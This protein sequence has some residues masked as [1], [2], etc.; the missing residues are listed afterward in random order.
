MNDWVLLIDFGASFSRAAIVDDAGRVEPVEVDGAATVPSGVWADSKGR[1]VTGVAARQQ[2]RLAPERW[3][4]A[5]KRALGQDTL[6]LGST[7]VP[8]TDAVAAVLRRLSTEAIKRRGRAPREVRLL[9]PARWDAPRRQALLAAARS[10]G[11]DRPKISGGA[12]LVDT[13]FAAG[14]FL[15]ATGRLPAGAK[16]ALFD[17]GGGGVETSVIEA[18]PAPIGVQARAAAAAGGSGTPGSAALVVVDRVVVRALGGLVGLGGEC[19]DDLLHKQVAAALSGID[20]ARLLE[21]PDAEWRRA[22]EG[23]FREVRRAKEELS[24]V[25][26]VRLDAGPLIN[27]PLQLT[28]INLEALLRPEIL[29][30]ARELAATIE[31]AGLRPRALH[32]VYLT[33]GASRMPLVARAVYDVLGV[34]PQLLDES[35]FLAGAAGWTPQDQLDPGTTRITS[36]GRSL[37]VLKPFLP[38]VTGSIPV[39]RPAPPEADEAPAGA[40]AGPGGAATGNGKT[41]KGNTRPSG[42]G[43]SSFGAT[44]A[45]A[46]GAG[47]GSGRSAF[48]TGSAAGAFGAG[49]AAGNSSAGQGSGGAGAASGG[50]AASGKSAGTKARAAEARASTTAGDRS[51][52]G[53]TTSGTTAGKTTFGKRTGAE[54][55]GAEPWVSPAVAGSRARTGSSGRGAGVGGGGGPSA[56]ATRASSEGEETSEAATGRPLWRRP[57]AVAVAVAVV[58]LLIGGLALNRPSSGSED[59]G[60]GTS[61]ADLPTA[62]P[63]A[64]PSPTSSLDVSNS[65]LPVTGLT[66]TTKKI[67]VELSWQS[68][69]GA[70]SYLVLRDPGEPGQASKPVAGT[71]FGDRPGDGAPHTYSVVAVDHTGEAGP[72]GASVAA[73]PAQT[74]YGAE[75]DI[76]SDWVGL[77]PAVPG[78]R[79]KLGQVCKGTK[80]SSAHSDGRIACRLKHG[81]QFQ[82]LRFPSKAERDARAAQLDHAK[83]VDRS[84]WSVKGSRREARHG[85][86]L[87]AGAKAVNGPFRWWTFDD[88]PTYAMSVQWPKHSAKSIAKWFSK[89]APFRG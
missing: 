88:A 72:A 78:S 84:K 63:T 2:A 59:D 58:A 50:R 9:A 17:L 61:G 37:E 20:S 21:P 52:S 13:P 89:Q 4:R 24:Q 62:T 64:T 73:Q 7:S 38:P 75:Q 34:Q 49:S 74:P 36:A 80:A 86:L 66:A 87:I 60:P 69:E 15:T 31:L 70:D 57:V 11:L 32:A 81:P 85:L 14:R 82:I 40:S 51:A 27:S 16:V 23:L 28:R 39:I 48:G 43:G 42:A 47:T 68:V 44:S 54:A 77:I 3:D 53:E 35:G 55:A 41:S 12:H 56:P 6:K 1:L 67:T 79:G 26:S 46:F 29:R 45:G 71:T 8:V 18:V 83:G 10:A 5:P 76:A 19:Y 30:S 22:A 25:H 33:G 65:L